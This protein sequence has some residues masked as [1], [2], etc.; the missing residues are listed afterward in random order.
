MLLLFK[1]CICSSVQLPIKLTWFETKQF[2]FKTALF[3]FN[4][5]VTMLCVGETFTIVL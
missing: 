2:S 4:D 3:V 5:L 1:N